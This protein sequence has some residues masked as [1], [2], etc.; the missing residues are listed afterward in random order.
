MSEQSPPVP[1]LPEGWTN[2]LDTVDGRLRDAIAIADRRANR[3]AAP[4][5]ATSADARRGELNAFAARLGGMPE[6]AAR[7]Q[8][9]ADEADRTL[10]DAEE[11]L[12]PLVAEVESLRQRL[13]AWAGRAIG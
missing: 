8:A 3:L 7:A 13:A 10:A 11:A 12:K 2:I 5:E 4:T 6:R 9:L 1:P